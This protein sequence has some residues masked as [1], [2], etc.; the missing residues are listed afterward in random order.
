[1]TIFNLGKSSADLA[2]LERMLQLRLYLGPGKHLVWKIEGKRSQIINADIF[3]PSYLLF[4]YGAHP[5]C[6]SP[7][8]GTA[9]PPILYS[10]FV[11]KMLPL[12]AIIETFLLNM[13]GSRDY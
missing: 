9:T 2:E 13:A 7:N 10:A 4:F 11:L 5:T 6:D 8:K 1:V 12:P 3:L